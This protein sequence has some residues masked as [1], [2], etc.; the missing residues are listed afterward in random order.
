M[1]HKSTF[2]RSVFIWGEEG[3]G[4]YTLLLQWGISRFH[5]YFL[6]LWMMGSICLLLQSWL[7]LCFQYMF[8]IGGSLA[9]LFPSLSDFQ[10]FRIDNIV[11]NLSCCKVNDTEPHFAFHFILSVYVIWD[12]SMVPFVSIPNLYALS[13]L[14]ACSW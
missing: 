7:Q 13:S 6:E 4:S 10:L 12:K 3:G 5:F 14:L 2:L 9:Y 8:D 11:V 1:W